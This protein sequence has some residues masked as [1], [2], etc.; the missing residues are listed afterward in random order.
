MTENNPNDLPDDFKGDNDKLKFENKGEFNFMLIKPNK[1]SKMDWMDDNYLNDLVNSDFISYHKSTTD[2]FVETIGTLLEIY[3]FDYP[4]VKVQ[5][6][7][8]EPNYHYELLYVNLLPKYKTDDMD[9]EF[10]LMLQNYGDEKIFGN[11]L[12]MKSYVPVNNMNKMLISKINNEDIIRIMFDRVNTK[13]IIYDNCDYEEKRIFGPIDK[14]ADTFFEEEDLY[15]IQ[16]IELP[17]LKHNINIWFTKFEY[18]DEGVCGGLLKHLRINKCIVFTLID[19]NYRGNLSME[20][21]NKIKYLSTKLEDYLTPADIDEEERDD[22]GRIII[23]NRFRILE[24][25]YNKFK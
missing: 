8:E 1:I 16:K 19:D 20:E 6:F 22:I 25:M 17:F 5:L 12:V 10:A 4:D 11:V 18:G 9:N 21:F 23:K 3:K 15:R 2:T 7:Y 14:F 24:L 13:C